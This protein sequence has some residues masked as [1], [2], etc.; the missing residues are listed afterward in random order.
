MYCEHPNFIVNRELSKYLYPR[1]KSQL[2]YSDGER[3]YVL[4]DKVPSPKK[5]GVTLDTFKN[6]NLVLPT[7]EMIN[8]YT[9]VPC[10][11]CI[12]CREKRAKEWATRATCETAAAT[13]PPFF[14]T[15]TYEKEYLPVDGVEKR[16]VQLFLKRFR[17]NYVRIYGE[18]LN[19]RYF[20][21]GEYGSKYGRPHY[22]LLL[23]NIPH[24]PQD[25]KRL[26]DIRMLVEYS[27]CTKITKVEY[28]KEKK[29]NRFSFEKLYYGKV[30]RL[31]FRKIG[32]V[33]VS[34][35]RGCS[36]AYCMKYMH[37]PAFCP[38]NYNNP[39]FYLSSRKNGG[40][41]VPYLNSHLEE[42]RSHVG[43]TKLPVPVK[44][45][46]KEFGLPRCF[47]DKL[48]PP[49]SAALPAG[50]RYHFE[51]FYECYHYLL[52]VCE[53]YTLDKLKLKLS[54]GYEN[55]RFVLGEVGTAIIRDKHAFCK[56]KLMPSFV[57]VKD[58]C[59]PSNQRKI[60]DVL[61]T[62]N[63]L[64]D[65]LFN[66]DTMHN[67]K[68]FK[69]FIELKERR[70]DKLQKILSNMPEFDSSAESYKVRNNIKLRQIREVF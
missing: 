21:V 35:D 23:W 56:D 52:S 68:S 54:I 38:P 53:Y 49:V 12:L 64:Y 30:C 46:I 41:G 7:G 39:S 70:N 33:D 10:G 50:T 63:F 1:V 48:W 62:F 15:L 61:F 20:A 40:I 36:S 14:I 37:K 19:L 17:E 31:F 32:R 43:M 22:H 58:A 5:F 18:R 26:D 69:T 9:P 24:N 44:N 67:C 25:V 42:F 16:D 4:G 2:M 57:P 65:M 55:I 34:P 8:L 45:D 59:Y 11:K 13:F 3:S 28:D 51:R 29:Y 47:K 6:Y 66:I 27:W 60:N